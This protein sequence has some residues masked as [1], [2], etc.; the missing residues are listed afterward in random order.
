MAKLSQKQLSLLRAEYLNK[1]EELLKKRVDGLSVKLFDKIFDEYLIN[2]EQQD[3]KL[4][5]SDK[6]TD[7]VK[8]L[9]T[10]FNKFMRNENIP[11]VKSFI[12]DLQ[13]ITP[14]NER[15]FANI[16]AEG[17]KQV[18]ARVSKEVDKSL[19]VTEDGGIKKGGYTDKVIR[20]KTILKDIKREINQAIAKKTG[21]QELRQQMKTMIEGSPEF[22]TS[23]KLHQYYRN[24]AYDTYTK[25]DR[26]NQDLFAKDLGLRYFIWSGGLIP[27]SRDMCRKCNDKIIDSDE[28]Q[29]LTYNDISISL[30]DG[31]DETW[32][33]MDDLGGYG[34][35]H[36]KNYVL[37]SVAERS[38]GRILDIREL[39]D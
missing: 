13:G 10:I 18:S 27:T 6:N 24:I 32:V 25:V 23:G 12:K 19:G 28:F 3:G 35:R 7:I 4:L 20:D 17:I 2:L 22:P 30:R 14:L 37:T 26:M 16:R 9:D 29:H 11:V 33:P 39:T 21:F 36:L 15:Y 38:P 31:I 34:C 8:G 5:S 1:R